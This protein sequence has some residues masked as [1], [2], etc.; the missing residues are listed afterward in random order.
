[1]NL[2]LKDYP[3]QHA[4]R[5]K[6]MHPEL[7]RE[8]LAQTAVRYLRFLRKVKINRLE[9][10]VVRAVSGSGRWVPSVPT[11]P[12]HLIVSALDLHENRWKVI[13]EV[14]LPVNPKFAGDGLS[15]DMS[16]EEM[17]EFFKKAVAEQAPYRIDLGGIETDCL[18]VECDCEH[19][20]WPNHG[21]CNGGP[22]NVPF[23]TLLNIGSYG[24]ELETPSAPEYRRKLEKRSFAP[25]APAGMTSDIRN[26][27][28]I[29]FRGVRLAVG[30]SLVRPMLTHL[31]WDYSGE[32]QPS[33]NRLLFKGIA[34][35]LSGLNGPSYITP[36]GN[37][38]AQN[39]TGKVAV[40]GNQVRYQDME[41]GCGIVINAVFTVTA[42]SITL[43]LEQKADRDI[44]VIEGEAWRL[45]W[46][47]RTGLTGV[48]GNPAEKEGRNGFVNLPALIAAD[49]GGC[50]AVRL[51][52]GNGYFHTES[53]RQLETR[54]TGFILASPDNLETPLLIPK[55]VSRAVFELKPCTLLP[56]PQEKESRL[57]ECVKKCWAA[58]F[59]AFRPEFGGFSNNAI[60][61]NCH[62]NQHTAFDF[63][64]FTA[65]SAAGMDPLE[66]VKFSIGRALMAGGGYGY[67]RSLYMDSD[68]VLLSGAGRIFQLTG[69]RQWL[70]RVSSGIAVADGRILGNF[71]AKE[72]MIVCRALSG[73]SGTYRWSSNAMDV[74]GFG[75]I[76][77]YV[78]AWS[79]RAMKNAAGLCKILG[80]PALSAK[81]AEAADALS[82]NYARQLVNPETGWVS[83]WKSRDGQLH[84]YGFVWIN[85]VACAFGV[86]GEAETK[87][88]LRNLEAKRK[89]V[90]PES[91]Y[92]GLPLNLLPITT[93]DHM[94]GKDGHC[95]LNPTYENY[96]DGALSPVLS[97]YYIRALSAHGF[98]KE[99]ATVV[100]SLEQ[101]FADG[102]FH[103]PYGT[104]KEFMAWTGADSGYEGT[105]GP[106]SGPLYAIAVERGIITPPIPEWWTNEL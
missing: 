53:Y 58:G 44:A 51:I 30:F 4:G 63:A 76:D 59:S 92:L 43:E 95:Q 85:G 22:F 55:G 75:H 49:D 90:F 62:V 46:N 68:P 13:K 106:N 40:T 17:E 103:G 70:R 61:T 73:N 57:P 21:E 83:G 37:F 20:V 10:P 94:L 2:Q 89:E 82:E 64:A 36:E 104:G 48:A 9:L 12:A 18:K 19:P 102:K 16:I 100:D 78:N 32:G 15:Q 50:L 101:G 33:G 86:M 3:I 14:E 71:D 27:L 96:T 56:V 31:S 7:K 47:M 52:E 11:H 29:V 74:I 8:I 91:G 105:F 65:R 39:M 93:S 60:S 23:G 34:D 67:H 42:D 99:S 72:G 84:D 28:E 77:A 69:D 54:S 79:F 98:K 80:E 41:T 1:M 97:A 88:A 24:K 35:G 66:L 87:C 45:L 5:K 81:C 38:I 25:S 26:P 6:I